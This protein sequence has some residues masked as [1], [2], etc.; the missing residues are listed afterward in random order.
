[1]HNKIYYTLPTEGKNLL[2]EH[3]IHIKENM[4]GDKS[5]SDNVAINLCLSLIN[6]HNMGREELWL[7]IGWINKLDN[8]TTSYPETVRWVYEQI[9]KCNKNLIV[10]KGK[11]KNDKNIPLDLSGK[12]DL[13]K[14]DSDDVYRI[15][16]Y[17]KEEC[18][19]LKPTR[20]LLNKQL[21][22]SYTELMSIFEEASRLG[23]Q[24]EPTISINENHFV[25]MSLFHDERRQMFELYRR[26]DPSMKCVTA[27]TWLQSTK[28]Y[29][30]TTKLTNKTVK[31]L[32]KFG[33][34]N[35]IDLAACHQTIICK[36]AEELGCEHIDVA[37]L[38][39][40]IVSELLEKN[41]KDLLS[42]YTVDQATELVKQWELLNEV[43]VRQ[44][45]SL[46]DPN[47]KGVDM[48]DNTDLEFAISRQL[49]KI[50]SSLPTARLFKNACLV[51]QEDTKNNLEYKQGNTAST[52]H[53]Y[54][55]KFEQQGMSA[56]INFI[57]KEINQNFEC[58]C[59]YDGVVIKSEL[60]E[61]FSSRITDCE[62][63]IFEETGIAFKI[64]VK[65]LKEKLPVEKVKMTKEINAYID[66]LFATFID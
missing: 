22:S 14:L 49:D 48:S 61:Q 34:D 33:F 21:E 64:K 23:T 43:D 63:H 44:V 42:S 37:N 62:Q 11:S 46:K 7:S 30:I 28:T 15:A 36:R 9:E 24:I 45:C 47:L 31:E 20:I 3:F 57:E 13:S 25:K 66:R 2:P 39:S 55:T 19:A 41:N 53:K 51:V 5:M 29:R 35:E 56:K 58:V 32:K 4:F 59:R 8:T 54:L 65:T 17:G 16:S 18:L 38:R 40:N 26:H 12:P 50:V 60:V 6:S 52:M 27:E 10:K 1:M